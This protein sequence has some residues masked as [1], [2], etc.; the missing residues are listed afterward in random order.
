[1]PSILS[2]YGIGMNQAQDASQLLAAF[3]PAV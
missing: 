2:S 1:M 3:L